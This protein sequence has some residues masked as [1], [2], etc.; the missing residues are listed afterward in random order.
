LI[1]ALAN[2]ADWILHL[3]LAVASV[4][5]ILSGIA[6]LRSGAGDGKAIAPRS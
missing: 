1:L 2:H 5:L 6:A 4:S 3:W